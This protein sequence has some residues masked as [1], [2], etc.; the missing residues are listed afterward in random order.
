MKITPTEIKD[1]YIIEPDVFEDH[2]GWFAETYNKEKFKEYGIDINFIQ[3]NH[4]FSLKKG[5]LRGL[6]LQKSPFSQAKLVRCTRG[7]VLDVAVDLRKNSPTF[8]K[9]VAVE[10]TAQNKRQLFIPQGFAHGFIL[11]EDDTEFNY[12]VDNKYSKDHE[13][14]IRY[15]DPE[16]GIDWVI[17]NPIL[18]EKDLGAP[19][20]NDIDINFE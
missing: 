6:H 18:S 7:A 13:I 1:V 2:R 9:W 16:L 8:K 11:L 14:G 12:K 20:L 5:T 10:L 4:S 17:S 15:D 3:D 19:Y